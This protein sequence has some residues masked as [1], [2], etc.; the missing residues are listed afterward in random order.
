MRQKY[1]QHDAT[2]NADG[3]AYQIA[4]V[5]GIW[6]FPLFSTPSQELK[7]AVC[8]IRLISA[9]RQLGHRSGN[10]AIVHR[11]DPM[12]RRLVFSLYKG[13]Q[14]A[15]WSASPAAT[16]AAVS[17]LAGCATT[18]SIEKARSASVTDMVPIA[19]ERLPEKGTTSGERPHCAL[20]LIR[21]T[22]LDKA[23]TSGAAFTASAVNRA[24]CWP[25]HDAFKA[26]FT[27]STSE[28]RA[29]GTTGPNCSS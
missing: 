13:A 27:C 29:T 10:S 7:G 1:L 3:K 17:S 20:R 18:V 8:H 16:R 14:K 6:R 2:S 21:P 28:K 23:S 9:L 19:D 12:T 26:A 5:L 25:F 15:E 4:V 11:R 22:I 24:A